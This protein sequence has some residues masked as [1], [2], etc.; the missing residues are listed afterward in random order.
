MATMPRLQ[1]RYSQEIVPVLRKDLGR[2]SLMSL[3]RL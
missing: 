1:E 3:P 2:E